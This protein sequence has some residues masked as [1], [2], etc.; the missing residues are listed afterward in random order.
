MQK[1]HRRK[2]QKILKMPLIQIN[3]LAELSDLIDRTPKKV[4]P[5]SGDPDF[6][7]LKDTAE[8]QGWEFNLMEM[9]NL[10]TGDYTIKG[11]E[12]KVIIERKGQISE[13]A[14][15]I[16]EKRF[17]N[18]LDRLEEFQH[19]FCILEFSAEDVKN[20][21]RSS[22]IPKGKWKYL[23]VSPDLILKK[24]FEFELKYKTRFIF[25]GKQGREICI[26]IFKEFLHKYAVDVIHDPI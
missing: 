18:E 21:P 11:F 22:N 23:R 25:A 14:Q 24:M 9:A 6:I 19:P 2:L 4:K 13:F 3:D 5:K 8:K 12:S 15:N 7:I 17:V 20:F 26:R 10:N 16:F 1:R